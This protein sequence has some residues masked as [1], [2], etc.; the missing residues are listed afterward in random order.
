[1]NFHT[2]CS[3]KTHWATQLPS[4]KRLVSFRGGVITLPVSIKVSVEVWAKDTN[5]D[6]QSLLLFRAT[7]R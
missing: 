6:F 3:Q 7:V 2:T 5:L 4:N 1:M